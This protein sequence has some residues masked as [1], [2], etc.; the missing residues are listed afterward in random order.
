MEEQYE[1]LLAAYTQLKQKHSV[2]KQA[3]IDN[4]ANSDVTPLKEQLRQ[5]DQQM[6]DLR[7]ELDAMTFQRDQLSRRVEV[8]QEDVKSSS[9]SKSKKG[10]V[11]RLNETMRIHEEEL[12]RKIEE[13]AKLH[14]LVADLN[15]RLSSIQNQQ[16]AELAE[17]KEETERATADLRTALSQRTAEAHDEK[18]KTMKLLQEIDTLKETILDANAEL[19]KV[20]HDWQL[21]YEELETNYKAASLELKHLTRFSDTTNGQFVYFNLQHVTRPQEQALAQLRDHGESL[22]NAFVSSLTSTLAYVEDRTRQLSQDIPITSEEMQAFLQLLSQRSSILKPLTSAFVTWASQA[23][24]DEFLSAFSA[25]AA[26]MAELAVSQEAHEQVQ[27]KSPTCTDALKR[28]NTDITRAFHSFAEGLMQASGKLHASVMGP[29][30]TRRVAFEEVQDAL[31]IT[32][33]ACKQLCGL[34][35]SKTALEQRLLVVNDTV[36]TT[37]SLLNASLTKLSAA[38]DRLSA[39]FK[40]QQSVL[41]GTLFAC[42]GH[43]L[44][45]FLHADE[46]MTN[47]KAQDQLKTRTQQLL[48]H[49]RLMDDVLYQGEENTSNQTQNSNKLANGSQA[50]N[51]FSP[52]VEPD[53]S[54]A[55]GELDDLRNKVAVLAQRME[56]LQ[57]EKEQA[58]L[59]VELLRVKLSSRRH[60]SESQSVDESTP[61]ESE[62]SARGTAAAPSAEEMLERERLIKEHYAAR[63]THLNEQL[64]YADAKATAFYEECKALAF[65]LQSLQTSKEQAAHHVKAAQELGQQEV[66]ATVARLRQLED[67]LNLTKKSYEEQLA[68]MSETLMSLNI[69]LAER[70]DRVDELEQI[71]RTRS[72]R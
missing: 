18:N 35:S 72:R 1:R 68:T 12:Q 40:D 2:L 36:K 29:I 7:Q 38:A 61:T 28:I 53:T 43:R 47:Y 37:D 71:M 5:K 25:A 64:R 57:H 46:L 70:Q 23:R 45:P 31:L 66:A 54:A 6:R 49:V 48:R 55:P 56:A 63:M 4:Q 16:E 42:R 52:V 9:S 10:T 24:S 8:L 65:K 26:F 20:K 3:F 50:S 22:V 62:P 11:A 51:T 19:A 15:A 32:Q 21:R 39:F 13:N 60:L 17:A 41:S 33:T 14:T 30:P 58:V 27:A 44:L 67:E 34:Y 59:E 69:Q